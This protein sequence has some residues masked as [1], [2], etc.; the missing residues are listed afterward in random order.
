MSEG[1]LEKGESFLAQEDGRG[2]KRI[3]H[4]EKMCSAELEHSR[5]IQKLDKKSEKQEASH[6]FKRAQF[7]KLFQSRPVPV[8]LKLVLYALLLYM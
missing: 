3:I 4:L 6:S 8:I 5:E 1:L 2:M 7:S